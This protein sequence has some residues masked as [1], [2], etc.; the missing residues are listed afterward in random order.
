MKKVYISYS[1]LASNPGFN[2]EEIKEHLE[3]R[4]LDTSRPY[5]S[6]GSGVALVFAQ[7]DPVVEEDLTFFPWHK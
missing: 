6:Y 5:H 4:G 7:E 1:T 2:S 3:R